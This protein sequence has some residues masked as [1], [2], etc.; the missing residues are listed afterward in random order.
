VSVCT[1][2]LLRGGTVDVVAAAERVAVPELPVE[3]IAPA[4]DGRVVLRSVA[5]RTSGP[6]RVAVPE[7]PF[8]VA[9]TH[10]P[11]EVN[12]IEVL[13]NVDLPCRVHF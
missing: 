4:L 9:P 10:Q 8:G 13:A 1:Q 7:L 12:Y 5:S 6:Q 11:P 2:P 3:V